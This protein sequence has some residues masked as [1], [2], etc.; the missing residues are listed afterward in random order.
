MTPAASVTG[1]SVRPS[2]QA[3]VTV[4]VSAGSGSANV[5]ASPVALPS[6]PVVRLSDETLGAWFAAWTLTLEVVVTVPPSL[7]VTVAVTVN[8][9]APAYGCASEVKLQTRTARFAVHGVE[10]SPQSTVTV[11]V[12]ATPGSPNMPE[13]VTLAPASR[14]VLESV[15]DVNDGAT[16][17][18]VTVSVRMTVNVWSASWTV[19]VYVVVPPA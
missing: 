7:S 18:T 13:A 12:S 2:P 19:T 14:S 5:S 4:C 10:P 11:C 17:R 1:P 15:N 8:V 16:F 3:T 6:A 9:P